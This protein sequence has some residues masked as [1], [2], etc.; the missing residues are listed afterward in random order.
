M[1]W[2]SFDEIKRTVS[3]QMVLDR[4][5]FRLRRTGPQVL[6]GKC[7]LPSHNSRDSK[8]S[9]I[10]TLNK[11]VGGAW[12]CHS[13]SCASGRG[14]KLGGNTLDLVAAMEGCSI[15]DAAIKLQ[16]W[17]LVPAAGN[18][19]PAGKEP[20]K[21]PHAAAVA[22]GKEPGAELISEK[23]EQGIEENKPLT[24][25]LKSVDPDHPYLASRG[26]S[27]ETI[28]T[29]GVAHCFGKGSMQGRCVI[30]IHNRQGDLVAY[31]GRAIDGSEPK[32][33]FPAGFR[34]SLEL[35]NLHRVND[36]LSV[37]VVEGFF[38][39]ITVSQAGYPCVAL[40]GSS[41]SQA[42]E[43]LVADRFGEVILMLDG[44]EAGRAAA[45]G[46]ADRL[47]RRVFAVRVIDLPDGQQPDLMSVDELRE[48]LT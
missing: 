11:G 6:R 47:R 43:D 10:A 2:V 37:V 14:G 4:Y 39:C 7:P 20:G 33:K 44:D 8:E 3:L 22:A 34:K 40:M 26:L 15:R 18:P 30:P 13:Q 36:E 24:F 9:F 16:T 25:V 35:F 48:V 38:D 41:M 29:F 17:F 28:R 42:Q 46:I 23:T 45:T 19:A 27:G 12:S 32:Y 31:A 1:D 21:E 5:G